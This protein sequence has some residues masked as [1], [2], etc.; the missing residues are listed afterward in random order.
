MNSIKC[1]NEFKWDK[2][3]ETGLLDL[4]KRKLAGTFLRAVSWKY[5]GHGNNFERGL[6]ITWKV[7]DADEC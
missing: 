3:Q 2:A 6:T 7:G 5:W 1:H 4:A